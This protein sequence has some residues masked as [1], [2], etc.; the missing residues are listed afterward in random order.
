MLISI[1]HEVILINVKMPTVDFIHI[2][3]LVEIL[4]LPKLVLRVMS[5]FPCSIH[6]HEQALYNCS[7]TYHD[8][9]PTR[10]QVC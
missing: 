10:L 7:I 2:L 4:Q 9:C 5:V 8:V 3:V 1:E 6:S